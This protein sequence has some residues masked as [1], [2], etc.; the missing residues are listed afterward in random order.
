[1]KKI[2]FV[3]RDGTILEEPLDK[4]I[5]SL[6]KM[7]FVDGVIPALRT[8]R[9]AGW[10]LILVSNQDGLGSPS[11]PAEDFE[12]PQA[13]MLAVLKSCGIEFLDVLICPHFE[14]DRCLCRKPKTG[15]VK[16]VLAEGFDRNK[17]A[18]IG[19]RST[20]LEFAEA[21][22][23]KGFQLKND[24]GWR[25]I[26]EELLQTPRQATLARKSRE[27]TVK[28]QVNLDAFRPPQIETGLRFFDH[29][30]EQIAYHAGI[31]LQLDV[32][33]DWS[34]DDHHSIEDTGLALGEVLRRA[35][36]DKF[37]IGRYGFVLPMDESLAE[38]SLDLSGRSFCKFEAQFTRE[39]ING[40]ATEMIPHFFR[41]LAAGLEATLHVRIQGENNHHLVEAG[42]KAFGRCLAQAIQM[43]T[44][45]IP[46]SKGFL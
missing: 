24:F 12:K 7:V 10:H 30:L 20:D 15:L 26:L 37:G 9:S 14:E 2:I 18:V 19:D 36:G 38:L 1:M 16:E 31:T 8:L 25:Q 43:Q 42:F 11:F 34:V 40:L 35:L 33:G 22:G 41:S 46:S 39:S 6:E 17:S 4:Q 3:D 45:I 28:V 21:I 27:T 5:D 13:F 44:R 32:K 29:M 23:I